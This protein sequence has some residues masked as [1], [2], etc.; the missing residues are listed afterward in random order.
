MGLTK[1][2]NEISS[3]LGEDALDD[4][5]MALLMGIRRRTHQDEVTDLA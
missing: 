2:T 5:S 1:R 4:K 3:R